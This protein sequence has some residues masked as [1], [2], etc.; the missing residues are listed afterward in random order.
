MSF[1][2]RF[3]D[4]RQHEVQRQSHFKIAIDGFSEEFTLHV[5][6]SSLVSKTFT[7]IETRFFNDMIKQAGSR[8]FDDLAL[9][10]H[11]AIGPDVERKLHEW[12]DQIMNSVTGFMGYAADYKRTATITEYNI[13]GTIRSVW[14]F[15]G[16]WPTNVNY[17]DLTREDVNKKSVSATL[18][19][20]RARL[21]SVSEL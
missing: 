4:A 13:N 1:N 16:V 21:K 18:A 7:P 3:L 2:A 8:T 17:G 5:R 10:I 14:E 15:E 11:D 19:Y 9:Q 20:D 6:T 12:Q